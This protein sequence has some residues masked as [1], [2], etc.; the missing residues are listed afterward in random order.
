MPATLFPD[1]LETDRL[2]FERIELD[3]TDIFELYEFVS[4]ADWQ[5]AATEHMP[6]FRFTRLDQ[7]TQFVEDAT[8]QWREGE[9]A[10]YLLRAPAEDGGLVGTTAFGPEWEQRRAGSGI[11][12]AEEYWGRE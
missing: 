2:I 1:R 11:I 3:R 7:V 12:L 9:T 5:G 8:D 4:R 6:W 10:R